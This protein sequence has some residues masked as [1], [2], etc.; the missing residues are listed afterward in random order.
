MRAY[1]RV[2]GSNTLFTANAFVRRD[3]LTYTPSADPF[4]DTPATVGQDRALTNFGVKADVSIAAG[5][6]S[7]KFGATVAATR[8]HEQFTFG[9]T[10]PADPAF[11]DE[12]GDF[13]PDLAPF[14]L[15]ATGGAPLAYDQTSTIKQQAAYH[16]STGS[17]GASTWSSTPA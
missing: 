15:T 11:A 10:D 14:D 3:H 4:N 13:N 5:P 8:L 1:S 2:I 16:A 17:P 9:I 7:V 12:N 6:H